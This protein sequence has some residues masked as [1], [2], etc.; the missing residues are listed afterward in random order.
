MA[1]YNDELAPLLA[2]AGRRVMRASVDLFHYK[3][4]KRIEEI[5]K[6]MLLIRSHSIKQHIER[7]YGTVVLLTIRISLRELFM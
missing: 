6:R 1:V 3:R 4:T 2:A 7:R 5:I